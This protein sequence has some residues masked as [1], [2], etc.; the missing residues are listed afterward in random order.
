MVKTLLVSI[1]GFSTNAVP[2][3]VELR[4]VCL[5][6]KIFDQTLETHLVN[7]RLTFTMYMVDLIIKKFNAVSFSYL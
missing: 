7:N 5:K 4:S 2:D 3:M 6:I 1:P